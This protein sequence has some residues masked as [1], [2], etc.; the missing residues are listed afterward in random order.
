L[1]AVDVRKGV[2]DEVE[3]WR[4]IGTDGLCAARELGFGDAHGKALA[5]VDSLEVLDGGAVVEDEDAKT[6]DNAHCYEGEE[7]GT[8][9]I[10]ELVD[11]SEPET[12]LRAYI[13]VP[14]IQCPLILQSSWRLHCGILIIGV[15]YEQQSTYIG[16]YPS[17]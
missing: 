16:Y 15:Q 5:L 1:L 6:D 11:S 4:L 13:T 7:P 8:I 14:A 2:A 10:D 3:W 17:I 12:C 9:R